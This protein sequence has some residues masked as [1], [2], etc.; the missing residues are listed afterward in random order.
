MMLTVQ[1]VARR[2]TVTPRTVWLWVQ[3]GDFP[4]PRSAGPW[5]GRAPRWDAEEVEAW[6]VRLKQWTRATPP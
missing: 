5:R 2:F 3:R 1:D 6:A 4:K